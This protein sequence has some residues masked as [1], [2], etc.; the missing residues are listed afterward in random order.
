MFFAGGQ[1]L[2]GCLG[3]EPVV[4]LSCRLLACAM[5]GDSMTEGIRAGGGMRTCFLVSRH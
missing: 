5:C 2:N 3:F 1:V 4:A